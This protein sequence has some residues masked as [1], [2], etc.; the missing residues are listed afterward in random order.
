MGAAWSTF[1]VSSGGLPGIPVD[2]TERAQ[3]HAG[4]LERFKKPGLAL[5]L[6]ADA[7]RLAASIEKPVSCLKGSV[8]QLR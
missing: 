7:A 1:V 8:A 6:Q 4:G 5:R 3:Q 2:H